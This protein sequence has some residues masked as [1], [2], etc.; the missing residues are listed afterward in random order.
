MTL[1]EIENKLPN[2]FHDAFLEH[3]DFDMANLTL[4][5]QL[6]VWVP[7]TVSGDNE[8]PQRCEIK[9]TNVSLLF[10]SPYLPAIKKQ[11]QGLSATE[12]FSLKKGIPDNCKF[13][14]ALI[15]KNHFSYSFY[16]GNSDSFADIVI[17]A[18]NAEFRWIGEPIIDNACDGK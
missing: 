3:M 7:I 4:I 1:E 16:I 18:E 2:G 11:Q 15:N 10:I 9:I 12:I 14:R 17:G 5:L 13:D 6:M 8:A